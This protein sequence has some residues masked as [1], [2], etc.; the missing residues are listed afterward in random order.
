MNSAGIVTIGAA[1]VLKSKAKVFFSAE[2]T[3]TGAPQNVA[4]GLGTT[5]AGVLCVPSVSAAGV[6]IVQGAHGA[7]NVVI[8]MAVTDKCFVFAWA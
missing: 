6:S 1:K 7:T 8:T 4:H 2:I 3:G 5:P